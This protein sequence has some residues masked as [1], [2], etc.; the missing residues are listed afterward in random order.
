MYYDYKTKNK[1]FLK[2]AKILK[3]KNIRNFAFPL[4]IYDPRLIGVD[5]WSE[6]VANSLVLQSRIAI[7]VE[8]NIW[9]YLREVLRIPTPGGSVHYEIH[10]G[11]LALT[12]SLLCNFNTAIELPR[13]HYKTYSAVAFYSWVTLFV[14]KNYS[15]IFTHKSY[16]DMVENLRKLKIL[17]DPESNSIPEY[18]IPSMDNPKDKDNERQFLISEN[19]NSITGISPSSSAEQADKAG[20]FFASTLF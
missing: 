2:V 3:D 5:P 7:E 19:N 14:A 13:Q 17:A 11:N 16:T 15:M 18:L 1:S 12:F 6:E 9:Y 8:R 4:M 10:L 20:N